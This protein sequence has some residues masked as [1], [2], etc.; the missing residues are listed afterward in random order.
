MTEI[1]QLQESI[2]KLEGL[3]E[4][5]QTAI[6]ANKILL[7]GLEENLASTPEQLEIVED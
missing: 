1:A 2:Q 3:V 7:A 6:A 5:T 4:E